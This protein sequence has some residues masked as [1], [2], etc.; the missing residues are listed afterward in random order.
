MGVGVWEGALWALKDPWVHALI[1]SEAKDVLVSTFI[2]EYPPRMITEVWAKTASAAPLRHTGPVRAAAGE[3]SFADTAEG[4]T[5]VHTPLTLAQQPALVQLSALINVHAAGTGGVQLKAPR[6]F[7]YCSSW[8]GHTA[9]T[10][11]AALI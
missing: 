7:A 2:G 11:T 4:A 6:T 10:H 3:A 1:W 9:A 8:P 5:G